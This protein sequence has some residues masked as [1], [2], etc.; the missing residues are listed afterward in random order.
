MVGAPRSEASPYPPSRSGL[1]ASV[2]SS[3]QW[4]NNL[5]SHLQG[6]CGS[7]TGKKV[8]ML[9][10]ADSVYEQRTLQHTLQTLD[11]APPQTWCWAL[12]SQRQTT[13]VSLELPVK[14]RQSGRK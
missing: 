3:I 1:P 6:S 2:S 8:R 14:W 11:L 4:D 9:R 12:E 10:A 7:Q 5:L 13:H